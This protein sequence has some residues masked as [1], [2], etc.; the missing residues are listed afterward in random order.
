[1]HY[2]II[3][4]KC[5]SQCKGTKIYPAKMDPKMYPRIHFW[6][7]FSRIYFCPLTLTVYDNLHQYS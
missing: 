7:H 5:I 2:I 1:M 3:V 6:I 4:N